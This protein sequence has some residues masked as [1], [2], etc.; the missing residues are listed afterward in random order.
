LLPGIVPPKDKFEKIECPDGEYMLLPSAIDYA[1]LFRGQ[2]QYYPQCSPSLYRVKH[3]EVEQ[4]VEKLRWVEFELMLRRYPEVRFFE[5]NHFKIDYIGLAQHY[6]L[7]TPV[8]DLTSSFDVATF[9]AMCDYDSETDRYNPK[10]EEKEYIGY[11]YA[12]MCLAHYMPD[13]DH[14]SN[15]KQSLSVIGLQPFQR[16]GAQRGFSLHLD[17]GQHFKAY[18]YSFSYTKADSEKIWNYYLQGDTLWMSDLIS[19]KTK[20][21]KRT[22]T[23]TNE[24]FRLASQWYGDGKTMNQLESLLETKGF[25]LSDTAPWIMTSEERQSIQND[26]EINQKET[27]YMRQIVSRSMMNPSGVKTSDAMDLTSFYMFELIKAMKGGILAPEG[28]P[29]GCCFC[30]EEPNHVFSLVVDEARR[31]TEPDEDTHR[32][33]KW[34]HIINLDGESL[35]EWQRKVE[36]TRKIVDDFIAPFQPKVVIKKLKFPTLEKR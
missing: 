1:F 10:T 32:V 34:S 19:E 2:G 30:L 28:Y 4:F 3:D 13:T 11:I 35:N 9:F 17:E 18:L 26:F 36:Q 25:H 21:I 20:L 6:G 15:N 33:N 31:Q 7:C 27:A 14:A 12:Y 16:P 24:A 23:F 29:T 22:Q 5:K 8:L